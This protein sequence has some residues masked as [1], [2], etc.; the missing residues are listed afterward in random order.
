MSNVI[1]RPNFKEKYDNY[2]DGKFVP[3]ASGSYFDVY[4]P[5]D[6]KVFTKAAHSN[7]EDLEFLLEQND[8]PQIE[9][10]IRELLDSNQEKI[11]LKITRSLNALSRI[12]WNNSDCNQKQL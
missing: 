3:P 11:I 5:I 10:K 9:A 8:K 2:I 6:G 1:Q 12:Y 4:S 7:K